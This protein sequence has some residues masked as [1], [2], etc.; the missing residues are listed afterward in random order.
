[1]KPAPSRLEQ[2]QR[3][4]RLFAGLFL[5]CTLTGYATWWFGM[6]STVLQ[7]A[8]LLHAL[9]G[10]AFTPLLVAYLW[11]H[12][13][14]T[15]GMRR[16][17]VLFS[18][19]VSALFGLAGILSGLYLVVEGQAETTRWI[20]TVHLYSVTIFALLGLIHLAL[21]IVGYEQK[22][23]GRQESPWP[24][25][26]QLSG[27]RLVMYALLAPAMCLLLALAY[28][29]L[30]PT[31]SV[32][33][34][35]ANYSYPY[36][37]HP[38][39]PSQTETWHGQFVDLREIDRSEDCAECHGE[40]T[41]QWRQSVHRHAADDPTY[42]T[43][44][45]LLSDNKGIAAT[46]YCEG[47]HAPVALL[48]GELS[49]GGQHG[50]ITDTAGNREGVGCLA[51][52]NID[53]VEHTRGVGSYRFGPP[54]GYLFTHSANPLLTSV[55]HW[56]TRMNPSLH[57]R[58]MAQAPLA[59]PELCAT[60]H[61]QFMDKDLNQWGWVKMQDDYSAWRNSPFSGHNS[62][63]FGSQEVLNC[64][65]C[66]MGMVAAEDPSS[67]S[68]GLVAGHYFPAANTVVARH[69]GHRQQVARSRD[70]LR[71][72]KISISIEEPNRSDATQTLQALTE[73]LRSQTEAPFFYYLGETANLK[74]ILNNRG[75]GH[76]FPGGTLD[77]NEAW[78]SLTVV[79]GSGEQVYASGAM[80][81]DEYAPL[82][83]DPDAYFYRSRPVD[84]RGNLVW[85]HD[86]FNR[87]GEAERRV[88]PAGKSDL[89]EYS[90][91]IPDWA[92]SPLTVVATLNYRKLNDRY[93][94]WALGEDYQPVPVV[95]MARD[96]LVIPL[97]VRRPVSAT[98]L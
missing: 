49:E 15:L 22:R 90:F 43:N 4:V 83:V 57:R 12:F 82:G 34:V 52:H 16:A 76:G 93:A 8:V 75:V 17:G 96:S 51:C 30:E 58:E 81:G 77:L 10:I 32:D 69:F 47:C 23:R 24:S 5:Y 7:I 88:I 41:A 14:R 38:F 6:G 67:D 79:D 84:R 94:R 45:S 65:D 2:E 95:D 13:R 71:G 54:S 56:L 98:G 92:K 25:L 19:L 68:A 33:P 60:C 62:E 21:H 20:L 40:I 11:N 91:V 72:N 39:R 31:L 53:R 63:E 87:V 89:V 59:T 37:E 29:Q 55:R 73:D 28:Q 27:L 46:R 35:T 64:I 44:I 36:G 48:T 97:I 26:V 61:A 70:F 78:V 50:G 3:Q 86:L 1:V 80:S 18:G 9:A 66:H 74:V 42:V 85:Q